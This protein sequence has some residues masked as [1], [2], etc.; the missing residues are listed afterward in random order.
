MPFTPKDIVYGG[1]TPVIVAL[2][3]LLIAR[4]FSSSDP[5]RHSASIALVAGFF[6]GYR[7]L[8]L[9]PWN[10]SAHWHWLPY[11]LLVAAVVGPIT[12]A[13]GVWT[14]ERIC[15]Y[16]LV[17]LAAGWVLVPNWDDLDPSRKVHLLA[18]ATYV[19]V[20]ACLFR[21]LLNRHAGPLLPVVLWATMTAAAIVLALSGSL[22]FAQIAIALA[23]ALFGIVIVATM[24]R[25]SNHLNGMT[26]L[27]SVAV[28]GALLIG[29]VNSF[30][31]VPLAS[32][33]LIPA[34]PL[35]VWCGTAGPLSRLTGAKK[36]LA[37]TALPCLLLAIAVLG[38]AVAELGGAGEY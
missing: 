31:Q 28:V 4:R 25:D 10:P 38:A 29:R 19:V 9:A 14:I 15:L 36:L 18:F 5:D 11:A 34:A 12:C 17:A 33:L 13:A 26:L 30:S 35:V 37:L 27:F 21:P 2:A 8:S 24:W 32:Y 1:M 6:A 3:V 22:R 16:V 7:L 20:W 23:G